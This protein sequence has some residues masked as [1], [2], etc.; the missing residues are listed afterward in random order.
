MVIGITGQIGSGK[1]TATEIL[2]KAGAL[3]VDADMIGR[4]VVEDNPAVLKKLVKQFGEGI[5]TPKGKLK[6]KA[7][8]SLA[9]ASNA[10]R[11]KLNAIVHPYLLKELR[12]QVKEKQ[13]QAKLVIVDA[14][15]LLDWGLDKSIDYVIVIH[16]SKEER[17]KRLKA[18]GISR[19]DA[20]ARQSRQLPFAEYKK[21]ADKV[22]HNNGTQEKLKEKLL[23]VIKKLMA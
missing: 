10:G 13:K 22:I 12:R 1:S 8:A 2:K 4:E 17:F 5:V 3:V 6:R 11:D 14:A 21:R 20:Q 9:F 16:A 7:L 18:R 15:L 23:V 19:E